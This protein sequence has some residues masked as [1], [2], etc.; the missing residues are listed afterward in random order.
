MELLISILIGILFASGT[1][2][3]LSRRLLRIVFGTSLLSHGTLLFL[4]TSGALQ[5]GSAPI[6]G[7]LF[8]VYVDPVPQVLLLTAIVINFAV[9]AFCLVLAYRTCQDTGTDDV[10]QLSG[11]EEQN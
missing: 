3:L 8:H 6:L 4:M 5:R 9:T 11:K 2:M 7:G 1:Y 10:D